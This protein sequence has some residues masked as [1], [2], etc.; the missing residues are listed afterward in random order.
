MLKITLIVLLCSLTALSWICFGGMMKGQGEKT[1]TMRSSLL[2]GSFNKEELIDLEKKVD[3]GDIEALRCLAM[4][5]EDYGNRDEALAIAR[6]GAK[7]GDAESL[8]NL[9]FSCGAARIQWRLERG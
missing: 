4:Y 2:Q 3:A 8:C 9:F 1:E 7:L 5:Y 6:K